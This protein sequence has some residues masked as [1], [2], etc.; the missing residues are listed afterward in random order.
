MGL[1][2]AI[3]RITYRQAHTLSLSAIKGLNID[4]NSIGK[5]K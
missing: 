5:D 3:T 1:R 4:P 2:I